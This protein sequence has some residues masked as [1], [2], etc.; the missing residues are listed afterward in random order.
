MEGFWHRRDVGVCCYCKQWDVLLTMS[1][2]IIPIP[3]KTI[4]HSKSHM[5]EHKDFQGKCMMARSKHWQ[6]GLSFLAQVGCL[7][8]Q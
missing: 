5:S 3:Q 4:V 6:S 8:V 7:W 1:G 2:G